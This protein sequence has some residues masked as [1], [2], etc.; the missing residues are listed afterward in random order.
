MSDPR[1]TTARVERP[2]RTDHGVA[3]GAA[4]LG[5][6]TATGAAIILTALVAGVGA[7]IGLAA[8]EDGDANLE[9][10]VEGAISQPET[11]GIIG[12]VILAAALFVSYVAGGYV[13]G[14]MARVS[15]VAQGLMVW[16]WAVVFTIV[17]GVLAAIGGAQSDAFERSEGFPLLPLTS[18]ELTTASVV[19]AVVVALVA[20]GG[21]ILGSVAAARTRHNDD[22]SITH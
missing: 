19:I 2:V 18:G 1:T 13:A 15:P 22:P 5:W 21:A 10:A 8:A 12:A 14:R 6:L 16:G 7:V 9:G 20:L 17:V 3:P 4:F 11:T